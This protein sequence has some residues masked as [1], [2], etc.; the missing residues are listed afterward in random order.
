MNNLVSYLEPDYSEFVEVDPTGRYGRVSFSL[1]INQISLSF[2]SIFVVDFNV[3]IVCSIMKF[4]VKELQRLCKL[5]TSLLSFSFLGKCFL[6][7][8]MYLTL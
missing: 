4:W 1:S 2:I 3:I 7:L 6:Y 5:I 8:V